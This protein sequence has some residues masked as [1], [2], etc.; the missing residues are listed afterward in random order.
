V[1]I[2][3][4]LGVKDEAE[5]LPRVISHLFRIG[6]NQVVARDNSSTDGSAE[7]LRAHACDRLLLEPMTEAESSDN[8]VWA[9]R[10]SDIARRTG[11][12][13][14]LFLDA[15][16]F[17]LP[18]SGLL[19]ECR[20]FH[21]AGVDVLT[22]PRYNVPL[23]SEGAL[24]PDDLQ[25]VSLPQ[26]DLVI[27]APAADHR[28]YLELNP[29]QAWIAGVPMPKIAVR[30]Q[31]VGALHLGHHDVEGAAGS[32][33]RHEVAQDVLIAHLPFTTLGR[34]ERKV[35]NIRQLLR[36]HE[37]MFPGHAAWHWKRWAALQD[38]GAV[39]DEFHRQSMSLAQLA[40]MRAE[41]AIRNAA[42]IFELTDR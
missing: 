6:V 9:I 10:E 21:D 22:V 2:A 34:F 25:P 39:R 23:T 27:K 19:R 20:Q 33:L 35:T 18:R 28:S 4:I 30:P 1:Q 16:E 37:S 14:V 3:A 11:A 41:G 15:D 5:L 32:V 24:M 12:D 7:Y 42:E 38:D 17:W 8:D 29:R 40:L 26:L 31:R 36:E 13:W